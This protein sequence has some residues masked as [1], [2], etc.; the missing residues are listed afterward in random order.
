VGDY[1]YFLGVA[2]SPLGHD[3]D[4][5]TGGQSDESLYP[6]PPN[7]Q[8]HR[9][10]DS[11]EIRG[12]PNVLRSPRKLAA[13][14]LLV[15]FLRWR[16]AAAGRSQSPTRTPSRTRGVNRPLLLRLL[17]SRLR[18][19]VWAR[20]YRGKHEQWRAL[21]EAAA[22]Q[23]APHVRMELVPGDVISDCI[24]FTGLYELP[25]TRRVVGLARRGGT[26]VDV[27]ANLGYFA[28]LWAAQTPANGCLGLEA[29][30]RNIQILKRNVSRNGLQRRIEVMPLAAGARPGKLRF[31]VGP[32]E[33]TGWGGF[34][35]GEPSGSIDLDVVRLDEVVRSDRPIALLKV[36]VEGADAWVLMGCERLL[37]NRAIQEVWYEQNKPR[38]RALGIPVDAAQDYL[39]AVGY[40]PSPYGDPAA[41]VVEWSA[42]PE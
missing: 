15:Q 31:D 30:P 24:A 8:V 26:L 16:W 42:V 13:E 37:T 7:V 36:D 32:I 12:L 6:L 41:E 40:S 10:I 22:L 5:L 2:L 21:Y 38:M 19:A 3:V 23:Y 18:V 14:L 39:R 34:V 25:L 20:L 1:T 9:V 4:V 33:Q 27:G 28:L 29:S 11:R 35:L 17:P